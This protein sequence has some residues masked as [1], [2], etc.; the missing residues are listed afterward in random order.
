MPVLARRDPPYLADADTLSHWQH[1]LGAAGSSGRLFCHNVVTAAAG[2]AIGPPTH[3]WIA[4]SDDAVTLTGGLNGGVLPQT[5]IPV[6]SLTTVQVGGRGSYT[7]RPTTGT[8]MLLY[9]VVGGPISAARA[10]MEET[11]IVLQGPGLSVSLANASI[12][13]TTLSAWLTPFYQQVA[14]VAAS[15]T[16]APPAP[17]TSTDSTADRLRELAQLHSEGLI[18]DAEYAA[19]RA[20]ILNDI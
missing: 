14:S 1:W 13:R 20:G 2:I 12:P 17:V 8:D 15:S 5:R 18:S 19:K 11:S 7:G 9:G 4:I 6:A 10:R 3:V 16:P